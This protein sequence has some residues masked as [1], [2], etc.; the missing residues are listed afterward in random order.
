MK[1]RGGRFVVSLDFELH[2]GVR[3]HSTVEQYRSNL[4]GVRQ[5]VPA[6]LD[7]FRRYEQHATWATVGALF[8]ENKR[9]LLAALP[10]RQPKYRDAALSPYESIDREVGEDEAT[11]PFHFAPSLIKLIAETPHQELGTHTFSHYYCM[12]EGQSA[13]D[14]EADLRAA[15]AISARYRDACRSIVFPRNQSNPAYLPIL[16][17]CGIRAMRGNSTHW[18]YRAAPHGDES[19]VRRAMRLLDTYLPLVSTNRVLTRHGAVTD[20]PASVFFRPFNAKL[21]KIE[22]V[23]IARIKLAM[24]HAARQGQLFHLWW[25]P[26]NFGTHL[27][28]NLAA[29]T[30]VLEHGRALRRQFGFESMTMAEAAAN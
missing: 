13:E 18:A 26:H 20:V 1:D 10:A 22:P 17:R 28:E 16:A 29:L 21:R 27:S 6:M 23:R 12:E 11:D 14:F 19:T 2:W 9:Q 4:L 30:E 8:A 5:A 25:H 7:L 3:D 15:I 24:T